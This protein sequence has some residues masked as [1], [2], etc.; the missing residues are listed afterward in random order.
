MSN[1]NLGD[2]S[3]MTIMDFTHT[4][5]GLIGTLCTVLIYQLS[6]ETLFRRMMIHSTSKIALVNFDLNKTILP[7]NVT[8]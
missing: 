4:M 8:E 7:T 2:L 3:S 1:S 6:L 5:N